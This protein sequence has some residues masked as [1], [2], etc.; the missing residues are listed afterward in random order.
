M[1]FPV[2][3]LKIINSHHDD[4]FRSGAS[5][6][7]IWHLASGTLVRSAN[8]DTASAL[9]TFVL[10]TFYFIS[11]LIYMI[12]PRMENRHVQTNAEEWLA[13]TEARAH[14]L[15]DVKICHQIKSPSHDMMLSII[16]YFRCIECPHF[17]DQVHSTGNWYWTIQRYIRIGLVECANL[18]STFNATPRSKRLNVAGFQLGKQNELFAR[19]KPSTRNPVSFKKFASHLICLRTFFL[20]L[21][22]TLCIWKKI[23]ALN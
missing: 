11:I 1:F 3:L 21:F 19:N 5:R 14:S 23:F 20:I 18:M 4:D 12:F 7:N 10:F 13:G 22:I 17:S 15:N 9:L 16:F 2:L 6:I 8:N